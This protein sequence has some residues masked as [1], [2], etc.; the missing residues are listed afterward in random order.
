MPSRHATPKAPE[1]PATQQT[2]LLHRAQLFALPVLGDREI[3]QALGLPRSTWARLKKDPAVP[4]MFRLGRRKFMRTDALLAYMAR[5]P[6]V[7][8]CE[9]KEKP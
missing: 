5:L 8:A 2:E 9:P 3:A 7:K 1:K 6:Q 4:P